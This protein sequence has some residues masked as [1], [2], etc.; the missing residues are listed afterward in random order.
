[1]DTAIMLGM[2]GV[3]ILLLIIIHTLD[4]QHI[5]LKLLLM[6][7]VF[8]GIF[9]IGAVI[10]DPA[11]TGLYVVFFRY[12]SGIVTLFVFYMFIYIVYLVFQHAKSLLAWRKNGKKSKNLG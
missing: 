8:W 5:L 2:L 10:A 12:T 7:F 9:I 3:P 4:K 6:F 1:M 11:N